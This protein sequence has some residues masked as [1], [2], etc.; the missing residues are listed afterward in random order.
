M[1]ILQWNPSLDYRVSNLCNFKCP[2]CGEPLPPT[3]EAEKRKH[4]PWTLTENHTLWS[5]EK[6]KKKKKKKSIVLK[7]VVEEEFWEYICSGTVEE[8][9]WVGGEPMYDIHWRAMDRLAQDDNLKK[10]I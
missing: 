9:Y 5:R 8:L 1:D 7:E 6:K 10:Y 2:M 4:D 3:W